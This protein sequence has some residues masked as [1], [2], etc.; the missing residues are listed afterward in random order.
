MGELLLLLVIGV[1]LWLLNLLQAWVQRRQR[2]TARHAEREGGPPVPPV[3]LRPRPPQLARE[4]A[5]HG[6]PV[7]AVEPRVAIR[8]RVP[9]RFGS[10]RDI[11]RGIVLMTI[12]GPCRAL[13]PPDPAR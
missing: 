3:V 13:E 2:G 1:I 6:L 5:R 11:R 4:M 9:R 8:Q 10:R 7:P 12:L